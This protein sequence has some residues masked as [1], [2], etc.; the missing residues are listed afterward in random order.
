MRYD[1]L[2]ALLHSMFDNNNKNNNTTNTRFPPRSCWASVV[3]PAAPPHSRQNI[4]TACAPTV[5][6]CF[7]KVNGQHSLEPKNTKGAN[8]VLLDEASAVRQS[9]VRVPYLAQP[10]ERILYS[11]LSKQANWWTGW[12]S[13]MAPCSLHTHDKWGRAPQIKV[14]HM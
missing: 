10:I 6:P 13:N 7:R 4:Q 1:R 11:L 5:K 8:I 2:P 3:E 14:Q 9:S 12:N